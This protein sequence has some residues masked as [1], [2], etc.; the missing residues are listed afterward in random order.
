M[1]IGIFICTLLCMSLLVAA[2]KQRERKL[3]SEYEDDV[4]ELKK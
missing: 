3:E 2:Y 1:G 4:E